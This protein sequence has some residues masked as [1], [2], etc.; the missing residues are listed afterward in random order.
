MSVG[1]PAFLIFVLTQL[2]SPFQARLQSLPPRVETVPLKQ[3]EVCAVYVTD[4]IKYCLVGVVLCPRARAVCEK[5]SSAARDGRE[6]R[7]L[8]VAYL[9][10]ATIVLY[11]F[12][13]LIRN[14]ICFLLVR[15]HVVPRGAPV[16]ELH[17][18]VLAL[19]TP[20]RLPERA[21]Y[22]AGQGFEYLRR[23]IL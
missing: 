4:L 2:L 6:R 10:I 20:P 15:V 17:E 23:C 3:V 8:V 18:G 13:A 1:G 12:H 14:T 11:P 21:P 19:R 7:I 22:V 16:I 5:I 9:S